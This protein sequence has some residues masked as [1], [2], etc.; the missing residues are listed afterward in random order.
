MSDLHTE[1]QCKMV[2]TLSIYLQLEGRDDVAIPFLVEQE[3]VITYLSKAYLLAMSYDQAKSVA[4]DPIISFRVGDGG[5]LDGTTGLGGSPGS[6][7]RPLTG[8]ETSLFNFIDP[9][10]NPYNSTAIS[11]TLENAT[12][13]NKGTW[14]ASTN[15]N[16][17]D[18]VA[19]TTPAYNKYV[20]EA[21][22]S[23]TSSSTEPSWPTVYGNTIQDNNITWIVRPRSL[24]SNE[25]T[26][27]FGLSSSQLNGFNISE[28]ALFKESGDMFNI[29]T[30]ASLPKT[31][32]FSIQFLWT[33]KYV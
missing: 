8:D 3:N 30:F 16:S 24:T 14:S 29:K 6:N 31:S 20:F 7:P 28:V 10:A 22:N 12:T 23:G 13:A 19:A 9:N 18:V 5:T 32:S 1:S 2:G 27:S 33:I 11:H 26:Y 4:P 21:Q 17:G 25:V 15:Y